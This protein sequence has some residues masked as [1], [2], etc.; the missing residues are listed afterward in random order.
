MAASGKRNFNDCFP[1]L[2][3]NSELT[4]HNPLRSVSFSYSCRS[5]DPNHFAMECSEAVFGDITQSARS[6]WWSSRPKAAV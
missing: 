2:D 5:T 4:C 1:A 6:G 3:L